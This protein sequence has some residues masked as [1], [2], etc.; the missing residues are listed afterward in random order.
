MISNENAM[1]AMMST[2]STLNISLFSDVIFHCLRVSRA[3]ANDATHVI[4]VGISGTG[5]QS[6]AKLACIAS[7][8][9]VVRIPEQGQRIVKPTEITAFQSTLMELLRGIWKAAVISNT[10][11]A[12]LLKGDDCLMPNINGDSM[13]LEYVNDLLADGMIPGL[14]TTDELDALRSEMA[15]SMT[16]APNI[17][18]ASFKRLRQ[19][20][21]VIM[22]LNSRSTSLQKYFSAY[23]QLLR[24]CYVDVVD[25]WSRSALCL[26]ATERLQKITYAS[27][28]SSNAV[29]LSSSPS[30]PSSSTSS[31]ESRKGRR[32]SLKTKKSD[33]TG[34]LIVD[35]LS[36]FHVKASTSDDFMELVTPRSFL[37]LLDT[38]IQ[39]FETTRSSRIAQIQK[40]EKGQAKLAEAE[41]G[42]EI[43][44]HEL[45]EQQ[46]ELEGKGKELALL[47]DQI[48]ADTTMAE[49]K[50]GEV[51]AVRRRLESEARE[52]A[53]KVAHIEAELADALPVLEKA[54]AALDAITS[55]DISNLRTMRQPPMLIKR[56][57]DAVLIIQKFPLPSQDVLYTMDVQGKHY[58][59]GSEMLPCWNEAKT[60]MADGSKFIR[61]L[62]NFNPALLN[63]ESIELLEPY[64]NRADFTYTAAKR[65]SGNIA[66][67]CTWVRSLVNYF[68]VAKVVLPLKASAELEQKRLEDKKAMLK[69]AEEELEVL[70]EKRGRGQT[71][72]ETNFVF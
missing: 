62:T 5:K 34:K 8:F 2:L 9:V 12:L 44:G 27:D 30:L 64:L 25:P 23:P 69:E 43:M 57:M 59:E 50:K 19:N 48:R 29:P 58:A 1:Q 35:T 22:C 60:M 17:I 61:T 21:R 20:L 49:R 4:I 36:T 65:S 67:V 40:L 15:A 68:H 41:R 56:I 70:E 33:E 16:H 32:K 38:F 14:F 3:L 54:L 53:K 46:L 45:K 13:I 42:T 37:G 28:T 55:G 24:K 72:W 18:Q 6:I 10:P 51:E 47:L 71:T 66:G 39:V 26:V 31:P 52:L 7:G 11:V 63:E